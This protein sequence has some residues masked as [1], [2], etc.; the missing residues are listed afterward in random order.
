[1]LIV[2]IDLNCLK[3]LYKQFEIKNLK[4]VGSGVGLKQNEWEHYAQVDIQYIS[5]DL[6]THQHMINEVIDGLISFA[7]T[8]CFYVKK[9]TA[10][11]LSIAHVP[12]T[13]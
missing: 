12:R 9:E 8:S 11:F 13:V 5:N 6:H 1:L 2:Y 10:L 3:R 7:S 4:Y